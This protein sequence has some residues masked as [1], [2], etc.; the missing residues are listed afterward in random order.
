MNYNKNFSLEN[1]FYID[2]NGL[3]CCEIFKDVLGYEGLYQVSDL[4]RIKSL[5]KKLFN[6]ISYFIQKEKILNPSFEKDGYKQISFFK[7]KKEKKLKVHRLV[8]ISFVDNPEN[9]PQIN[10]KDEIKDNNF[11]KNLE[12]LTASENM[13]YGSRSKKWI[14]KRRV[15][16]I[17]KKVSQFDLKGNFIQNFDSIVKASEMNFDA[18]L[19]TKCCKG[20][21]DFHKGFIWKYKI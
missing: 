11:Y 3:V 12:W 15:S 20:K 10:H 19:I 13:K 6:G 1:L 14:E 17:C 21:K 16:S 8:G 9:K 18:S 2:E 4:G 7:E 5:E